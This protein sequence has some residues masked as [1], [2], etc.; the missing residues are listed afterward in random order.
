MDATVTLDGS[1]RGT[2]AYMS[3]EQASGGDIDLRS[4]LWSAG[5]VLYEM[6]SGG[7]PFR[8]DSYLQVAQAIVH[9]APPPL[10][11]VRPEVPGELA[12]ITAHALEQD[13]SKRYQSAGEMAQDLSAFLAGLSGTVQ[14]VERPAPRP[15]YLI[16]AALVILLAAA[17][18]FWLY[19]RSERRQWA[20]EQAIPEIKRLRNENKFLAA[21][22]LMRKA[23]Q[24]FV[25]R[26]GTHAYWRRHDTYGVHPI[27]AA[28]GDGGDQ[29]LPVA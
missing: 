7:R 26:S 11:Q 13:R 21:F 4:D 14:P 25:S 12:R 16:P 28:R 19:H 23:E 29:G 3:P 18:A 9:D 1:S 5:V 2:P 15:R 17:A 10:Q 20:R 24:Y 8:G 27:V 6:L 22:L